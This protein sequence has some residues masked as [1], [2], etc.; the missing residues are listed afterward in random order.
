MP[1]QV[2]VLV[3]D[4][5]EVVLESV[6]KVLRSDEEHEFLLD[7]VLS[8][9][10]G[11][12]LMNDMKFDIVI[13][14]LMMPGLD[15]LQF[16]DQIRAVDRDSRII[17]ITGYA[18]MRT[19]LQ[20]LRKGAFDYIA[21]PFTKEELRSVVKNAARTGAPEAETEEAA[22]RPGAAADYRSF[23]HQ[24]YARIQPDGSMLFGIE[25]HFLAHVEGPLNIEVA[26]PGES[27]T[28][29]YPFGKVT[30]SSMRVFI[31]R[32]PFSGRVLARNQ[33]ALS[34]P[35]LIRQDARG[36]GW[37]LHVAPTDFENEAENLG[38]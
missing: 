1:E 4:D 19:A 33:E 14:D 12:A 32:A 26:E 15:G 7:C 8:A 2:K 18:T 5:E 27:V 36:E 9:D 23:F 11:L 13:T 38:G 17:M 28:Q 21:K 30:D 22:G 29:G 6:R 3:V 20:A 35:E 25:P 31:L 24:S 37:L 16:I 10:E 34:R